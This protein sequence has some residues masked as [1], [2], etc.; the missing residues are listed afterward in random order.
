VDSNLSL[1]LQQ[2]ASEVFEKLAFMLPM[3]DLDE[4]QQNAPYQMASAV[5]FRGPLCGKLVVAVYG[6]LVQ[7]LAANMLGDLEYPSEPQQK[8]ALKEVANV[9]CGNLVPYFIGA[10]AVYRIDA[11]YILEDIDSPEE[12]QTE[13]SAHLRIGMNQGRAELALFLTSAATTA[14]PQT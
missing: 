10:Q 12:A 4:Y 2:A 5:E 3:R 1:A 13:P 14:E 7:T 6:N 11:P 9:I 8:D